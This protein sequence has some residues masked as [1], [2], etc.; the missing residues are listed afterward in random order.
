MKRIYHEFSSEDLVELITSDLLREGG[1]ITYRFKKDGAYDIEAL[2]ELTGI[3]T[4]TLYDYIAGKTNI[5]YRSSVTF[6][7]LKRNAELRQ[8][9]E[10][11][12][13]ILDNQ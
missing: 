13:S 11:Y 1:L 7:L 5:S 2:S 8:N 6:N 3:A 4:K 10:A 9:I 12:Q